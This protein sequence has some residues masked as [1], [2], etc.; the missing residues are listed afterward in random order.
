MARLQHT[1]Y[2][3]PATSKLFTSIDLK[4]LPIDIP[5][6]R[7]MRM[8]SFATCG[9]ALANDH[10]RIRYEIVGVIG[11]YVAQDGKLVTY[12]PLNSYTPSVSSVGYVHV[13][14]EAISPDGNLYADLGS[15]KPRFLYR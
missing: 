15:H 10:V 5:A 2:Q 4:M 8:L 9:T 11:L 14:L 3:G 6:N 7:I 1:S 13:G 12:F